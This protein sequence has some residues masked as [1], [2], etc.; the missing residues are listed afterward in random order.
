MRSHHIEGPKVIYRDRF[1]EQGVRE[2][3]YELEG[4]EV[5]KIE[6][7]TKIMFDLSKEVNLF[8]IS[9]KTDILPDKFKNVIRFDKSKNFS[10]AI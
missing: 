5:K 2:Q 1:N 9:H 7:L 10:R 3:T 4:T 8:V 6:D